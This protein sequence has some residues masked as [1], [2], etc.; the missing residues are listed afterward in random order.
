MKSFD[1][2]NVIPFI[3]IMLVLLAIVLTT[4]TFVATGK[5]DIVMPETQAEAAVADPEAVRIALDPEGQFYL[6]DEPL[7]LSSLEDRLSVRDRESAISLLIDEKAQFDGFAKLAA[8]L[9][10]GGF[11]NV[12][13]ITRS[14]R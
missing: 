8:I 11:R 2:I 12:S 3:D 6:D 7:S 4:A 5:L 1:S 10:A 9:E 13:V 14:E